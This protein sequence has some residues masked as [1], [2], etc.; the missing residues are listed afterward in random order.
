[1]AWRLYV[2]S[3]DLA[4]F[5]IERQ[6]PSEASKRRNKIVYI[7]IVA[8]CIVTW[9]VY[10]FLAT[11]TEFVDDHFFNSSEDDHSIVMIN[12]CFMI[13]L[14]CFFTVS[15]V[16]FFKSFRAIKKVRR[17]SKNENNS[18]Y[19]EHQ[20]YITASLLLAILLMNVC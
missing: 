12:F 17:V 11:Y 7:A 10:S 20:H 6:L 15:T 9:F 19:I 8:V 2:A 4:E 18:R 1:M 5:A 14:A 3:R 13:L 16:L